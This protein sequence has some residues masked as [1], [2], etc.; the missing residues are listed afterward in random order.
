MDDLAVSLAQ[1]SFYGYNTLDAHRPEAD[2]TMEEC[3]AFITEHFT[4][5]RLAMSVVSPGGK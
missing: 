4:P 3:E 2:V 1:S 5:E